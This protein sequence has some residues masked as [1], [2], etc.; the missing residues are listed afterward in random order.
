[1][2]TPN[3]TEQD[4]L[5]PSECRWAALA[6]GA[7]LVIGAPLILL[8]AFS[9]LG[10]APAFAYIPC[11]VAAYMI[12]R[13]FRRRRSFTG[14]FQGMQAT[15]ILII[16]L[17]LFVLLFSEAGSRL[18][19]I[20]MLA[21]FLLFLYALWGALDTLLGS[22]F[23]YLGISRLLYRVSEANMQRQERRRGFFRPYRIDNDDKP[24][25]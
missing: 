11:A 3:P 12:A 8:G 18:F 14:S 19:L 6:H 20:C 5:A 2:Q 24:R 23:R 4:T 13:S 22:D 16:T 9:G 10:I 17:L 25:E 21:A 1:M 15:V 7:G